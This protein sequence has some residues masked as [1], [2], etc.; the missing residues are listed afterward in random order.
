MPRPNPLLTIAAVL[1]VA[2][3]LPLLFAPDEVIAASGGASSPPLL[4]VVQLLGCALFGFGILDWMT[5]YCRTDG[6]FGR[7][8]VVANLSHTASAAL[9]LAHIALR[10]GRS[11]LLL[12]AMATY[13]LLAAGFAAQIFARRD[14]SD[15]N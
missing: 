5:R 13:A 3:A 15:T 8:V 2:A 14:R 4:A 12:A 6:I 10:G 11:P 9:L 7:P 1:Y